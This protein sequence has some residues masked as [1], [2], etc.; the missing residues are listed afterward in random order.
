M[1]DGTVRRTSFPDEPSFSTVMTRLPIWI[2]HSIRAVATVHEQYWKCLQGFQ[3]YFNPT[4]QER[5]SSRQNN[6][7]N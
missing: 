7:Q 3:K 5:I 6:I 1:V 4:C 2:W